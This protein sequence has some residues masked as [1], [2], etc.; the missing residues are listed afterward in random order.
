MVSRSGKQQTK[1]FLR[2]AIYDCF[3]TPCKLCLWGGGG[4]YCF[5]VRPSVRDILVFL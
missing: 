2:L 5:H 1:I 3:Y 4:V